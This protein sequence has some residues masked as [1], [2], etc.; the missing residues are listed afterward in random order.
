MGG[1]RT[2]GLKTREEHE[3]WIGIGR[4]KSDLPG[5]TVKVYELE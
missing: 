2:G 3:R 5:L 4:G 1:R